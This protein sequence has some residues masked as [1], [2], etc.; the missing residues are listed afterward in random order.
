M[1]LHTPI[2]KFMKNRNF[3]QKV[4]FYIAMLSYV[5]A[6]A[7]FAGVFIIKADLGFNHPITSSFMASVVFFISVGIVLQVIASTNLPSLRFDEKREEE[8]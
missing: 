6:V 5:G 3:G 1:A 7:C 8:G 2:L 4:S